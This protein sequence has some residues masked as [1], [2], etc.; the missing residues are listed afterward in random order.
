MYKIQAYQKLGKGAK[1]AVMLEK[2]KLK[3]S[4]KKKIVK[5]SLGF[6][7]ISLHS[8]YEYTLKM[9]Y[10]INL[11]NLSLMFGDSSKKTSGHVNKALQAVEGYQKNPLE[12]MLPPP[13]HHTM[14]Y[15]YL[16]N[17]NF[18]FLLKIF[19]EIFY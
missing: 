15:L 13:L 19:F 1:A 14:I 3:K 9:V 18:F 12:V 16:S 5:C 2:L 7:S 10:A 6:H 17:G 8:E 4:L 11:A